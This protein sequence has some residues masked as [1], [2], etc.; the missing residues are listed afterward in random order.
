MRSPRPVCEPRPPPLSRLPTPSAV[1]S[2]TVLWVLLPV[3]RHVQ[4]WQWLIKQVPLMISN[5][6]A[7]SRGWGVKTLFMFAILVACG[8]TLNFFLLPETKGRTFNEVCSWL[9]NTH[10]GAPLLTHDTAGRDVRGTYPASK[11]EGPHHERGG[12][13]YQAALVH[14]VMVRSGVLAGLVCSVFSRQHT[15]IGMNRHA[16]CIGSQRV[17]K[18]DGWIC[19]SIVYVLLL[20]LSTPCRRKRSTRCQLLARGTNSTTG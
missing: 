11:D 14:S 15:V 17:T 5:S 1:P 13:G 3:S 2:T 12:C 20:N 4:Q 9:Y 8:T 18:D 6:G 10:Q 19:I 7:G 16:F